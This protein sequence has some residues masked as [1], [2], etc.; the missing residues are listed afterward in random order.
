M[1]NSQKSLPCNWLPACFGPAALLI[2][3]AAVLTTSLGMMVPKKA[4]AAPT[5]STTIALTPD[6][7]RVVVV[8]REANSISIIQVKDANGNDVANKLVEIGVGEEP[9]CVAV[10]PSNLA[11][12]VTN[13]ISGTVSVIDLVLGRE[14]TQIP[15]G[16]EPRGC[17]LTAD[18]SLLYVANHTEGMVSIIVI[19]GNP[20]NPILDGRVNVGGRP[21]AIAITDKGTGNI[22]DD[23]VFVTDVFAEL[24]PD[25]SD[26]V[27]DGNGE[28]RD[29]GKQGVVRAFP[30]GNGNPAITKIPIPALLPTGFRQIISVGPLLTPRSSAPTR[31]I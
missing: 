13:A 30:A 11:A 16:T 4:D 7:T 14:V 18:G 8:N 6:E 25:F 29:L 31:A 17:A 12:Y 23:T 2:V 21:W 10:H 28:A 27:F 20:L 24:N 3:V 22:S 5:R 26:P 19:P 15:V 9:R 1:K